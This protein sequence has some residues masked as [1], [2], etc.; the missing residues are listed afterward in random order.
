[1]SDVPVEVE[2]AVE[3][4]GVVVVESTGVVVVVVVVAVVVVVVVV[5]SL[6]VVGAAAGAEVPDDGAVV[7]GS[8]LVE[9]KLYLTSLVAAGPGVLGGAV[10][11]EA[12]DA[13][14]CAVAAAG[15]ADCALGSSALA[16][17]VESDPT[18]SS[19]TPAD[20][21]RSFGV[22]AAGGGE[23]ICWCLSLIT[24]ILCRVVT[25]RCELGTAGPLMRCA[26]AGN[27]ASG[28]TFGTW[29]NGSEIPGT[30]KFGIATGLALA[31]G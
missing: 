27:G 6:A 29:S 16:G 25:T 4:A 1:M 5:V 31:L 22:F 28:W 8:S 9:K 13:G 19:T 12:S 30:A 21:N 17:S 11:C 24:G 3:A 23:A 14:A 15:G 26:A 7:A 18:S 10:G 2:P 20:A